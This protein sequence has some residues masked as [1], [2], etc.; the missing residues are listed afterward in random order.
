MIAVKSFSDFNSKP[1][2]LSVFFG[3]DFV[4]RQAI[5]HG[6]IAWGW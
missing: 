6:L 3:A 4:A 1:F 5:S 2:E